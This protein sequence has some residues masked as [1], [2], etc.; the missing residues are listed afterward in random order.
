VPMLRPRDRRVKVRVELGEEDAKTLE[1]MLKALPGVVMSGEASGELLV[2]ELGTGADAGEG[3]A[4]LV[5][6]GHDMAEEGVL[7]GT[8]VVAEDHE[9]TRG[10]NWMGLLTTKPGEITLMTSDL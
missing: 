2:T 5:V 8:L 9:L 3:D 1:N 6:S 4:I 10:L 7:D